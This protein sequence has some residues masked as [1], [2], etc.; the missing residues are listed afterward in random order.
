MYLQI[1][2]M[3]TVSQPSSMHLIARSFVT[4]SLLVFVI[5]WS[6]C[7]PMVED[8]VQGGFQLNAG[9]LTSVQYSSNQIEPC[10][11]RRPELLP[12]ASR[13]WGTYSLFDSFYSCVAD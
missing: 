7:N 5:S 11:N 8:E 12:T 9:K 2:A 13:S 6:D 1:F 4:G 10:I 3:L